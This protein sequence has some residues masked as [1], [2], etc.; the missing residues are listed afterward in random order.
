MVCLSAEGGG[1]TS[2]GE[3][4]RCFFHE[5]R[6]QNA[7]DFPRGDVVCACMHGHAHHAVRSLVFS[8][9]NFFYPALSFWWWW[10]MTNPAW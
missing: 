3:S 5:V 7:G 1:M 10:S 4:S 9:L 2:W 8:S 6:V